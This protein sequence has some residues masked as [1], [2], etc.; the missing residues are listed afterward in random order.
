MG[1]W[2]V[3]AVLAPSKAGEGNALSRRNKPAR[4]GADT[5]QILASVVRTARQRQLDPRALF[6]TMLCAPEPVVPE[7]L[8]LPPP[9]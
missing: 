2:T 5:Q 1:L 7:A 9:A 4:R 6:T 3:W 8:A